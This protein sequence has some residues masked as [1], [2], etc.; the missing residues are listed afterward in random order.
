MTDTTIKRRVVGELRPSQ[1][2][3]SFG[4]GAIIDLPHISAMVLGLD[5]WEDA[6]TRL[7]ALEAPI[8][9]IDEA[10]LL[11]AV[12]ER[13]GPQVSELRGPPIAPEDS[14]TGGRPFGLGESP[15][16]SIGVPL[17]PF[18]QWMVCPTCRT[19]ALVSDGLFKFRP[20][21]YRPGESRYVHENCKTP[22]RAVLPAR[23]LVACEYGH[24][25]DFPWNEF[26]HFGDTGCRFRLRLYE[27]GPSGDARQIEV[28]C[29]E[30]SASRR[31]S[32][33][34]GN[35][36]AI[37]TCSGRHPHIAQREDL[38]CQA[39]KL[40]TILLG[41]SNSWFPITLAALSIPPLGDELT[42]LVHERWS[43]VQDI[44]DIRDIALLR[45]RNGLGAFARFSAEDL[46]A[47]IEA[48][49]TGPDETVSNPLDLKSPE[50]KVLTDP[51]PERNSDQFR[52]QEVAPPP[53]FSR[54][55]RRVVLVQKLRE[56]KVL[57][58]FTRVESPGFGGDWD[59]EKVEV[60]PLARDTVWWA[61][62]IEVRGEGI[63]LQ[64]DEAAIQAWEQKIYRLNSD[65]YYG[66]RRVWIQA[67][68]GS[69]AADD[70][71]GFARYL[72][73]HSFSHALMREFALECGYAVASIRERIYAATEDSESGPMAGL[74]L[75]T[76][77]SDSEG[78]LGGLVRLGEPAEL[79]RHIEAALSSATL[80]GSDPPCSEHEPTTDD[81]VMNWAACHACLCAPETSCERGNQLLDRTVLVETFIDAGLAF[82][83]SDELSLSTP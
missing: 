79:E 56:V 33:A 29:L 61:P 3:Y 35:S 64:F 44:E 30:C 73:I 25:D 27:Y 16:R 7:G 46:L 42:K 36:D 57:T 39:Q 22:N 9:V 15:G 23:F 40:Q 75:Y 4:I 77:A 37:G 5:S 6:Y 47:A 50:W 51:N 60:A 31:M 72:L 81:F 2:V 68:G 62:A 70:D 18:P 34:F 38:P 28:R 67:H 24:I 59:L 8:P 20:N 54:L 19:L 76:S 48:K 66:A 63:F 65:R 11:A 21:R 80:C 74:L 13:L 78:T 69:L 82:F 55:I 53:Q 45:R 17:R 10:R 1:L 41:A 12:R 43:E 83:P 71:G 26:V 58:G 52:L 49:R 32:D 14:T